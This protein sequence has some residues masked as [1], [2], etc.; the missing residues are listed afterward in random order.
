[1]Y[2]CSLFHIKVKRSVSPCKL[3]RPQASWLHFFVNVAIIFVKPGAGA[4]FFERN[5]D[6]ILV[7]AKVLVKEL[8][9]PYLQI[10]TVEPD[11]LDE[12]LEFP[13]CFGQ[14]WAC[15]RAVLRSI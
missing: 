11:Q 9:V 5:I 15:A 12:R 1:M 14:E 7:K 13:C 4:N 8:G 6:L 10:L 3:I 2:C